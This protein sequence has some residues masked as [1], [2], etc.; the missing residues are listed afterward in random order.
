[1]MLLWL[2]VE[3]F[4]TLIAGILRG[5]V[6]GGLC[7]SFGYNLN[8]KRFNVPA[9]EIFGEL[10]GW[11][12][13]EVLDCCDASIECDNEIEVS[14]LAVVCSACAVRYPL[15]FLLISI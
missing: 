1:M 10:K 8:P 4:V 3:N 9:G 6:G 14:E 2:N 15:H 7:G 13:V 11:D 5:Y 12:D